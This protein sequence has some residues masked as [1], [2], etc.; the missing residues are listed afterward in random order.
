MYFSL[1]CLFFHRQKITGPRV[2]GCLRAYTHTNTNTFNVCVGVCAG[3]G[4]RRSAAMVEASKW[5]QPLQCTSQKLNFNQKKKKKSAKKTDPH[6]R[7]V[8]VRGRAGEAWLMRQCSTFAWHDLAR[9]NHTHTQTPTVTAVGP[10]KYANFLNF[11]V[12]DLANLALN[13][14]GKEDEKSDRERECLVN[15][16]II[17]IYEICA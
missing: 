3:T 14:G 10:K 7:H 1:L 11:I 17:E 16:S 15:C 9:H 12:G 2:L 5:C 6:K 8:C 4:G 13:Q